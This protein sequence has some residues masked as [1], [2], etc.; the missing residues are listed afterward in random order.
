VLDAEC[1]DGSAPS[2]AQPGGVL[3]P[4]WTLR[5]YTEI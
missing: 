3:L 2:L 4:G 5:M 1:K